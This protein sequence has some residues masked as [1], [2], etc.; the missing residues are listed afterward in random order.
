MP[1]NEVTNRK[2]KETNNSG[3][4][5][6]AEAPKPAPVDE[7]AELVWWLTYEIPPNIKTF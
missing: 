4:S 3:S 2:G 1:Q 7:L 5:A 6:N